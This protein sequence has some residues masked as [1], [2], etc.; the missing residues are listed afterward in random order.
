MDIGTKSNRIDIG[1]RVVLPAEVFSHLP[2]ELYESKIVKVRQSGSYF[3]YEP[4]GNRI[5]E[6]T[7]GIVTVN[8]H[9]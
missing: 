3:L 2:D 7:N 1:V 9:S 5:N 6:N 8:G 4:Q